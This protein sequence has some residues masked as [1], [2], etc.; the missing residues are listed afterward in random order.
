MN[1]P[2]KYL[3]MAPI[4]IIPFVL[5]SCKQKGKI[6]T[7]PI[8]TIAKTDTIVPEPT[9]KYNGFILGNSTYFWTDPRNNSSVYFYRNYAGIGGKQ[10]VGYSLEIIRNDAV[11]SENPDWRINDW[12]KTR[13]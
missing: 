10:C 6:H 11:L 7:S 8:E 9:G 1:T 12:Y 13:F 2:L 5:Y 3:L 4:I